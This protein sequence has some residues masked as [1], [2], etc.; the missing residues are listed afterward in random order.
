MEQTKQYPTPPDNQI[1][2]L[3]LLMDSTSAAKWAVTRGSLPSN[4]MAMGRR[5]EGKREEGE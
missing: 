4:A 2:R 1:L 3:S 5:E